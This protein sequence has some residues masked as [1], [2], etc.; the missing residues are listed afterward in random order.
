MTARLIAK[1]TPPY[2]TNTII[3]IIPIIPSI[4]RVGGNE[5]TQ[6]FASVA[7]KEKKASQRGS[8]KERRSDMPRIVAF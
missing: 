8:D 4:S 2:P 6:G 3:P 5:K 1:T 7:R